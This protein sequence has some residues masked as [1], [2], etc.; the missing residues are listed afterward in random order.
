MVHRLPDGIWFYQFAETHHRFVKLR[1]TLKT[2]GRVGSV[3][4]RH[5]LEFQFD[6][7]VLADGDPVRA[8]R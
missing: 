2:Q 1:Y 7:D 5:E 8:H 4:E 3:L 6:T